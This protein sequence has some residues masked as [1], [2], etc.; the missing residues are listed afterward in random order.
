[1][2]VVNNIT[3]TILYII[4]RPVFYLI[5]DVSETGFFLGLQVE[6]VQMGSFYWAHLCRFH[7]KT[8]TESSLLN[9]VT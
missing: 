4:R 8:E 2:T 1:V 9:A 6:H 3:I 7:L 5:H